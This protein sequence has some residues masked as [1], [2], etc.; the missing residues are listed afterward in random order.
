MYYRL[1]P[2]K[3]VLPASPQVLDVTSSST[4]PAS[5]ISIAEKD[6]ITIKTTFNATNVTVYIKL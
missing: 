2:S 6:K 4:F 5:P 1:K 3:L